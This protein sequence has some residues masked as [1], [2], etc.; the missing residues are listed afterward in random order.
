[1]QVHSLSL[2]KSLAI[3]GNFLVLV[4][5]CFAA[6][7]FDLQHIH[8]A[9]RFYIAEGS[10][11]NAKR[12]VHQFKYKSGSLVKALAISVHFLVS[13]SPVVF[14]NVTSFTFK[15]FPFCKLEYN[16][17]LYTKRAS[18]PYPSVNSDFFTNDDCKMHYK[19]FCNESEKI[20]KGTRIK[21]W[22]IYPPDIIMPMLR[23]RFKSIKEGSQDLKD[24]L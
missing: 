9:T 8:V 19:G 3:S 6:F 7:L 22:S 15:N 14:Q 10:R 24:G 16:D 11:F 5:I 13:I 17:E 20:G 23:A 18:I 1:M 4:G 12:Q 2:M 21:D